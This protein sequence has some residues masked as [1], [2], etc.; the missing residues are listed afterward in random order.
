MAMFKSV[1]L[2]FL[3][4]ITSKVD[5]S[6][7]MVNILFRHGER[8][9]TETYPND[10]YINFPWP[11]GLG[12]LTNRGKLQ[13]YDTGGILR[14]EYD[15]FFGPFYYPDEVVMYTSYA[16]RTH[17]S[18][19]LLTAGLFPPKFQQVWNQQLLWQPIP[20]HEFPRELDNKIAMK[21]PCPVYEEALKEIYKSPKILEINEKN[22]DLYEYLTNHT[23]SPIKD[24]LAVEFL[25]NTLEIEKENNFTLPNWTEAVFPD[26]MK[27]LASLSLAI[28]TDTTLMKRL[29]AGPLLK[30]ILENMQ[31]HESKESDKKKLFLYSGHDI[32]LVSLMSAFGFDDLLKPGFGAAFNIE[33]HKDKEKSYVKFFYRQQAITPKMEIFLNTCGNPCELPILISV[34]KDVTPVNWEEECVKNK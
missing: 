30:E 7:E 26:K 13:M 14:T 2:L 10:P 31:N 8:S 20:A 22:K 11:G 24:I 15:N 3:I 27:Y 4:S 5:A 18:G 9:P 33:L 16:D 19:Q 28:F 17:M 6:L 12:Q 25:Y 1:A 29:R 21:K 23:G 32:T 34:L